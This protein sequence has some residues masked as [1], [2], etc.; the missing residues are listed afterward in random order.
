VFLVSDGRDRTE[1]FSDASGRVENS[2]KRLEVRVHGRG[3]G[4]RLIVCTP[5][6]PP[7]ALRQHHIETLWP[8]QGCHRCFAYS[9]KVNLDNVGD[10][11]YV[12]VPGP[13]YVQSFV[14]LFP[15]TVSLSMDRSIVFGK[16]NVEVKHGY[17]N[18]KEG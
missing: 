17:R 15:D 18:R 5:L 3:E 6:T 4:Q 8:S 1:T 14:P 12:S 16:R 7:V 2:D 11:G 10:L 13:T 9:K